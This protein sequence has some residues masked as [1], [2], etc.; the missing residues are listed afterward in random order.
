MAG[1]SVAR[2]KVPRWA[3][4]DGIQWPVRLSLEQCSSEAAA[5][6]KVSLAERI[7]RQERV[8]FVDLTGGMGVDFSFLAPLFSESL[9]VERDAELCRLARHNFPLLGL[10]S[11]TYSER[12]SEEML[13]QLCDTLSPSTLCFIDPARRDATGHKVV[14]LK[15]CS[16]DV[17]QI[18]PQLIRRGARI[19]I[20]LSP[21]LDITAALHA[22]PGEWE[23]HVVSV[24]GECRELLLVSGCRGIHA[25]DIQHGVVRD[26]CPD[27]ASLRTS[28]PTWATDVLQYL[29][30]PSASVLK[31]NLQNALPG[32]K[33]SASSHLFTSSTLI[34]DFPGR[35]FRVEDV[36]GFSKAE[37]KRILHGIDKA[38][39]T[40]RGFPMSVAALRRKL[41]LPEGGDT[42]LFAATLSDKSH[43]LIKC[44]KI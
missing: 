28:S 2:N 43:V 41:N 17:T 36:S 13:T 5:C 42:Y 37:I 29:Y 23:V 35:T 25:V 11:V 44:S 33:L 20:K 26:F 9:Y 19:M 4:V 3:S 39:L 8:R 1:S 34:E 15:D 21:M 6:Y 7:P 18:V 40:V 12:T 22:L 31:A 16:P 32:S 38:N 14:G 30:E 10:Q 24:D 27:E